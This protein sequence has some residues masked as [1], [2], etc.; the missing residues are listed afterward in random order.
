MAVVKLQIFRPG[1]VPYVPMHEPLY[2]WLYTHFFQRPSINI[3]NQVSRRWQSS[4]ARAPRLHWSLAFMRTQ[5]AELHS[6]F[7]KLLPN[8]AEILHHLI[9]R[10]LYY[11]ARIPIFC[12]RSLDMVIQDFYHQQQYSQLA[13][14]CH[15]VQSKH[16]GL[17]TTVR[18]S[19]LL[20]TAPG[21]S[22][23]FFA[24]FLKHLLKA[25]KLQRRSSGP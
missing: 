9:Y 24:R 13:I 8:E 2:P 10:Y 23:P 6:S 21:V 15:A 18:S 5:Q 25:T 19:S 22:P 4:G 12:I 16:M 17:R 20:K 1:K 11:A 14:A 3:R 7:L